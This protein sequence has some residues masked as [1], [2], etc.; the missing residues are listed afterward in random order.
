MVE[1]ASSPPRHRFAHA[2][3]RA[4]LY[5]QLSGPRKLH[6]HR[7]AGQ[8]I[9]AVHGADFDEHLPRLAH[10]FAHVAA[11]GLDVAVLEEFRREAFT[12]VAALRTADGITLH[13]A[14]SFVVARK[15]S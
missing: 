14:A 6:L 8:A 4:S 13:Q 7:A 2:I 10:H 15:R 1:L 3:V 12:E 5:E 11:G 9:D